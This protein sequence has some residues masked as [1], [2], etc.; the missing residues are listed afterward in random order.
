MTKLNLNVTTS[1]FTGCNITINR[2]VLKP[3]LTTPSVG[4]F[5]L[6]KIVQVRQH[7]K[8]RINKKWLKRY[9][10]KAIFTTDNGWTME[11]KECKK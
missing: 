4:D 9:G 8:K 1:S 5:C 7:K 3:L 11:V 6:Y 2:E 10:R